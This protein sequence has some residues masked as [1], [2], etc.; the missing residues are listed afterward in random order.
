LPAF[1]PDGELVAYVGYRARQDRP[2]EFLENLE[3]SYDGDLWV[4]P[5]AGGTPVKLAHVSGKVRGPV[6]SP[7]GGFIAAHHE[8]EA[9]PAGSKEIWVFPLSPDASSAGEPTKIALPRESWW[10]VAGWT[11]N[12]ELG[13]FTETESR[14]AVYTV[15]ASGGKAVQVTPA[16]SRPGSRLNYP[17]WSPDGERIYLRWR[18]RGEV[19]DPIPAIVYV[20]AAGGDVVQVPVRSDR[21]L[22][23]TWPGGGQNVSPDGKRIVMSGIQLPRDPQEG[24]DIWTIPLDS[25]TPTRLTSDRFG[26]KYPCWSPDG[27]WVAFTDWHAK[28]EDEHF[29]AISIVPAAGGDVR[30]IT[31]EAVS[32]GDGA[33]AFSPDGERIAFFSGNAIKTIPVEGGQPEV[34]IGHVRSGEDSQLAWSPDGSKIAHNAAGKIW[35]TR[36]DGGTLEELRT[37]LP[38]DAE[39]SDVSWS[40]DGEK[41]AFVGSIGGDAEFWLISDFLPSRD[42]R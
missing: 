39:L 37:G 25:G 33:I 26:A 29:K 24:L 35:I 41:I 3:I 27:Q 21:R 12:D 5:S 32:V 22:V 8:P 6:W 42:E 40:Q 38:R 18:E 7:D 14:L 34:L 28:S 4:V 31:S 20:P 2:T 11:P 17:R 30:Q 19:G 1:S 36:L 15:P 9:F 13:L 10:L 16:G 23:S